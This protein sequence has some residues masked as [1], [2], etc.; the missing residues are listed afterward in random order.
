MKGSKSIEEQARNEYEMKVI[1]ICF[2]KKSIDNF[3]P[4]LKMIFALD[5]PPFFVK[6]KQPKKNAS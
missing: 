2:D 3:S 5:E 1:N 6:L 4:G